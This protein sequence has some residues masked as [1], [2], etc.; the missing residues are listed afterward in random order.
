MLPLIKAILLNY[1]K[2][3]KIVILNILFPVFLM[4]VLGGALT[5]IFTLNKDLEVNKI[6]AIYINEDNI[7]ES[8]SRADLK[9][10]S[11]LESE[12]EIV[13]INEEE[14]LVNE[15]IL[16][17]SSLDYYSVALIGAMILYSFLIPLHLIIEEKDLKERVLLTGVSNRHYYFAYF[18]AYSI[19]SFISITIVYLISKFILEVNYGKNTLIIP[20]VSIPFI[21]LIIALGLLMYLLLNNKLNVKSNI[22]F[23]ILTILCFLGGG[24]MPLTYNHNKVLNLLTG[25]SPLRWFNTSILSYIYNIDSSMLAISIVVSCLLTIIVLSIIYYLLGKE[26]FLNAEYMDTI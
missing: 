14:L 3:R 16:L 15:D 1:S 17:P 6:K 11:E 2:K 13:L 7:E 23:A 22:Y 24:Y 4:I 21:T 19:V 10:M 20:I 26:G 8:S 18:I 5:N 9:S 12:F 25:I